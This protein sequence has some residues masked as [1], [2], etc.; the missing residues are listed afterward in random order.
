MKRLYNL[1]GFVFGIMVMRCG[2]FATIIFLS[3]YIYNH[4]SKDPLIVGLIVS[5][6]WLASGIGGVISGIF[7]DKYDPKIVMLIALFCSFVN[8]AMLFLISNTDLFIVMNFLIGLLGA[9]FEV[10]SKAYISLNYEDKDR[11]HAYNLRYTAINIGAAVGPAIGLWFNTHVP[12]NMFL[13]SAIMYIL[14]FLMFKIILKRHVIQV[15]P[16]T[17]SDPM[18][19]ILKVIVHDHKLLLLLLIS[20]LTFIGYSQIQTTLAEV[21]QIDN[22]S[23]YLS[24]YSRL[25]TINACVVIIFQIPFGLIFKKSLIKIYTYLSL[26]LMIVAFIL[27]ALAKSPVSFIIAIILLSMAEVIAALVVNV[28]IDTISPDN[29]RG[30]YYGAVNLGTMGMFLGPIIGGIILRF[31]GSHSLYLVV[32]LILSM[33]LPVYYRFNALVK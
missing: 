3:T 6:G 24:L 28:L 32:A 33:A 9:I 18:I 1:Y 2:W 11:V 23:N 26:L 10:A 27:F 15:K 16:Q 13:F 19:N 21:L 30:I 4:I 17:I 7:I 5:V 14:I 20:L 29:M 31:A 8:F 12:K 22:I 25:I